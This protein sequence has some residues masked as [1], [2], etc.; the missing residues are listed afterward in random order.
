MYDICISF[1][2]NTTLIPIIIEMMSC[3]E[4][5][6]R[7][8]TETVFPG[9][10]ISIIKIRQSWNHRIFIIWSYSGKTASLY[11]DSPLLSHL[12]VALLDIFIL[13]VLKLRDSWHDNWSSSLVCSQFT[14]YGITYPGQ[15]L[16]SQWLC[17]LPYRKT[18]CCAL[19][20]CC[21]LDMVSFMMM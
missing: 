18:V 1:E 16:F 14:T 20:V 10:E 2:D 3:M 4:P 5:G 11:W 13:I 7:C 21:F 8:N 19:C 17:C 9:M 15:R 12:G 6:S